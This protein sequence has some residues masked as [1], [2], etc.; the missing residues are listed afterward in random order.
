MHNAQY[1]AFWD[2]WDKWD[3][4]LPPLDL[5]NKYADPDISLLLI[6]SVLDPQVIWARVAAE[7]YDAHMFFVVF[8][9]I[10]RFLFV[11]FNHGKLVL[12]FCMVICV[13]FDF[14]LF[15]FFVHQYFVE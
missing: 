5:Y 6:Q 7:N 9:V 8:C 1:R 12:C 3:K 13:H 2:D 10:M 4:Y 11:V 14:G 15:S